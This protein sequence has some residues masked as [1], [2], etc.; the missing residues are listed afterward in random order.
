MKG[1][2]LIIVQKCLLLLVVMA[3]NTVHVTAE[4]LKNIR[5]EYFDNSTRRYENSM[6]QNDSL[7][8]MH[9]SDSD[10]FYVMHEEHTLHFQNIPISIFQVI[11]VP[12]DSVLVLYSTEETEKWQWRVSLFSKDGIEKW[13]YV[14]REYNVDSGFS[15]DIDIRVDVQDIILNIYD[16][17]DQTEY[18]KVVLKWDGTVRKAEKVRIFNDMKQRVYD[19]PMY[20]VIEFYTNGQAKIVSKQNNKDI[21]V[22]MPNGTNYF[23]QISKELLVCATI[24][25]KTAVF[26]IIDQQGKRHIINGKVSADLEFKCFIGIWDNRVYGLFASEGDTSRW[27]ICSVDLEKYTLNLEKI[28]LEHYVGQY[29][30][31]GVLIQNGIVF[32]QYNYDQNRL[33]FT[34]L[35]SNGKRKD[36]FI[37]VP[38]GYFDFVDQSEGQSIQSVLW[39]GSSNCVKL[40]TYIPVY[41]A[42]KDKN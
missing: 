33:Y 1:R 27:F 7:R 11:E 25:E 30:I 31:T 32:A 34:L 39:N 14:V 35:K 29:P 5:P 16:R 3:C 36:Y 10:L 19:F 20:T 37:G 24:G 28:Q 21:T 6:R 40:V 17:R 41:N 8:Q 4:S 12:D 23:A 18:C 38:K 13:Q 9:D 26:Q 2:F 22:S 42:L 15:S